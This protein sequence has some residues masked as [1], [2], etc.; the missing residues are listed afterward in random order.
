M[1]YRSILVHMDGTRRCEAR[2]ELARQL[3][4][5]HGANALIALL[6][7]EPQPTPVPLV[8]DV[9]VPAYIPEIDAEHRRSA[10]AMFDDALATGDPPMTWAEVPGD[11]PAWGMAQAA[12]YTDLM[13]LGQRD[14]EDPE[15]RDVPKDFVESVILESGKAALVVPFAGRFDRVGRNVLIAWKPTRECARAVGAALPLLQQ[16]DRVHVVCWGPE[17]FAPAETTFGI[18]RALSWHDVEATVHRYPE[19]PEGL[20]ELLLSSA[21]DHQSDLLVMGCY[22]HHRVRELLL[23]GATKTVLQAMTL[24]VLMA[25]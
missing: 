15:A 10:R 6:A 23:G 13:V 2:L 14:P 3:A 5:Q 25:H 9:G 18:V 1:D 8:M 11:P 17:N 19:V 22:G 24:P 4:R 20:G 21:A 12:L 7:L 16:A